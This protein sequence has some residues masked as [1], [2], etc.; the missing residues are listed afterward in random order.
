[1]LKK[2]KGV[3]VAVAASV[4]VVA[5]AAGTDYTSLTAAVDYSTAIAAVLLVC[6][7]L[8][9]VYIALSGAKMILQKLRGG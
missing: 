2:V 5:L 1:M 8:A 7:G 6:A 9:G 4:P 3:V